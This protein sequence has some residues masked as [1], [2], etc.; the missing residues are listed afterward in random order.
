M[1]AKAFGQVFLHICSV[2]LHPFRV[3]NLLGCGDLLL[4]LPAHASQQSSPS[5]GTEVL[6]FSLITW[7][8]FCSKLF[9]AFKPGVK[10]GLSH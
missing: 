8:N 7:S 3:V 10:L 6:R 2:S 1:P 9:R 5:E 4:G